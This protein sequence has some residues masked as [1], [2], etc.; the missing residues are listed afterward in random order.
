MTAEL[1]AG[2]ARLMRREKPMVRAEVR[3]TAKAGDLL[4]D[5]GKVVLQPRIA[6]LRSYRS[7]ENSSGAVIRPPLASD[8][9][10]E[11]SPFFASLSDYIESSRKSQDFET[12]SGRLAMVCTFSFFP[13]P[14][15]TTRMVILGNHS[16]IFYA[17]GRNSYSRVG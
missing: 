9:A 4:P 10:G 12:L 11:I 16:L 7:K 15:I 2:K 5:S 13:P 1:M 17:I 3:R 14:A 6:N 8:D